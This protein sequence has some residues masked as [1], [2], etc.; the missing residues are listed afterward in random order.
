MRC[1]MVRDQSN[2]T[3]GAGVDHEA[4]IKNKLFDLIGALVWRLPVPH[5]IIEGTSK[6]P[7]GHWL[8]YDLSS[9]QLVTKTYCPDAGE[10]L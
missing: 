8:S 7:G 3:I 2:S 6:L 4:A 5:S 10:L 1:A 9:G